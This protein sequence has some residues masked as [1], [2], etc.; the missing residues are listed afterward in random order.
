MKPLWA[1]ASLVER[2]ETVWRLRTVDLVWFDLCSARVDRHQ[3]CRSE[4]VADLF[5]LACTRFSV[6]A[7]LLPTVSYSY[8]E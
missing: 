3:L 4:F 1:P 6:L 7:F 5:D 8:R 2:W